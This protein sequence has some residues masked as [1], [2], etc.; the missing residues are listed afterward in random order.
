MRNVGILTSSVGV[1]YV[2]NSWFRS[3]VTFDWRQPY[4]GSATQSYTPSIVTYN[5]IPYEVGGCGFSATTE[6]SCYKIDKTSISS[7]SVMSNVYGDLG[8]W[9]G[10]TPY[11]GGG[12]GV[13]ELTARSTENFYFSNGQPY[14][15]NGYNNTFCPSGSGS[16]C[17]IV[18]YPGATGVART[19]FSWALMAGVAY[20]I[21]PHIKLDIGY[22]YFNMGSVP[23]ATAWGGVAHE[24]IDTQEVRVGLRFTPDL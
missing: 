20:D 15:S 4:A 23:V 3:D 7:W 10:F 8:T 12:V 16:T 13:T 9:E 2:F 21:M 24:T 22:R 14:N 1:G 6:T 5:N 17:Y 11:V 18:G 19:N